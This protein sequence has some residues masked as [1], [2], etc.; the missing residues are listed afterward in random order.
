MS[1]PWQNAADLL[2]GPLLD[3]A[4]WPLTLTACL[5]D[6]RPRFL[7]KGIGGRGHRAIARNGRVLLASALPLADLP[8]RAAR[9]RL[10]TWHRAVLPGDRPKAHGVLLCVRGGGETVPAFS[11]R[12]VRAPEA[13][14]GLALDVGGGLVLEFRPLGPVLSTEY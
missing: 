13:D 3:G 9:V 1:P 11:T 5:C 10:Q 2:R 8:G 7:P 6:L 14:F 4:A 12:L